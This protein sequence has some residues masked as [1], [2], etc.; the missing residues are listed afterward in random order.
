MGVASLNNVS[1]LKLSE[2]NAEA[3]QRALGALEKL[4][5]PTRKTEDW[6]Y[7]RVNKLVKREYAQS[8]ESTVSSV[9]EFLIPDLEAHVVVIE[10]GVV[11]NALSTFVNEGSFY[12]G[13]LSDALANRTDVYAQYFNK[14]ANNQEEIFTAINTAY[15]NDGILIWAGKNHQATKAVHIIHLSTGEQ[16]LANNRIVVVA[17]RSSELN[18]VESYVSKDSKNNLVNTVVE[19]FAAENSK[20]LID[21]L[22]YASNEDAF[23]CTD[24]MVQ[25]QDS[26]LIVNTFT[27]SGGLVR[28]TLTIDVEG[29][30]AFTGMNGLYMPKG[31]QHVD[32]HTKVNHK[33]ANCVSSE[34]YK[35]VLA[36]RST[37]VFNGKVIVF[38]DAQKIE[39]YQQNKNVLVST[40][41][42]MN[43][44]PELEIYADD[45]KCSHGTTTGQFDEAAV[46]YLQARG[47]SKAKAKELLVSAFANEVI[48]KIENP[49]VQNFVFG[50]MQ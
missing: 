26:N 24:Q 4:N 32:N 25:Q 14:L 46:F 43:A 30:N 8:F 27:L 49:V 48:E 40:D 18:V 11:N 39:A 22:Q 16:K 33:V 28:N 13:T 29:Q 6:K 2:V 1:E 23:I 15:N 7:T 34:L 17:E 42:T 45:V 5:F 38:E 36:D 10:N 41:A 47:I 12:V 3:T 50:L 37:G 35:G 9:D 44:K 19:A 31:K 20:L 21:K